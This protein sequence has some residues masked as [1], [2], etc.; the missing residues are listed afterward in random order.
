MIFILKKDVT[1]RMCVDYRALNAVTVKTST[2]YRRLM[3]FSTN[4][5]VHVYS[6]RLTFGLD[7][8]N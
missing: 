6:L 3:I 1:Q 5:V 8:I 2:P 7:N 4:L